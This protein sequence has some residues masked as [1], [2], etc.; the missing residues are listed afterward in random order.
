[1][2]KLVV[3]NWKLNP[4]TEKEA[5]RLALAEDKLNVVIAPPFPFLSAVGKVL[6]RAKLGAQD[7]FYEAEG[8]FTGAVSPSMLRSLGVR[9]VIVG[10]SERRADGESDA[11]VAKKV[12][13]AERAGLA[14]ILCVGEPWSVRKKGITAAKQFVKMQLSAD[15][16]KVRSPLIVAYEPIWAIGSGKA[17]KPEEAAE[18]AQFIK[19]FLVKRS[20][21]KVRVLY[22]G[23]VSPKNAESFFKGKG[24]DGALVG[25]SSLSLKQFREIVASAKV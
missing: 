4:K 7:A 22:G 20:K 9:Y 23:S 1:M 6:K 18:M 2:K 8:A 5:V 19:S 15:L 3:A 21:L 13:A 24:I 10:H 14:V 16:K 12:S 25:G 11:T 17:D